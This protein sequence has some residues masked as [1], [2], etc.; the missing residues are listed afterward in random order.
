MTALIVLVLNYKRTYLHRVVKWSQT[1]RLHFNAAKCAIL[2]FTRSRNPLYYQYV[3][4]ETPMQRVGEV[5]D[6]GVLL[7]SNLTFRDHIVS[8]C[9]KAFQNLGFVMRESHVFTNINA[10]RVL[11]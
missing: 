1:Y 3:L 11:Y 10:I 7:K 2:S 4:E 5:K 9:K 8:I 6:L